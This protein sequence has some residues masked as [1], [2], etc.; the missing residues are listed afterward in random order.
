[1][2]HNDVT[3]EID[4]RRSTVDFKIYKFETL[5]DN[6]WTELKHISSDVKIKIPE[7]FVV[8]DKG[9]YIIE[10]NHSRDDVYLCAP[11]VGENLYNLFAENELSV[12]FDIDQ[13]TFLDEHMEFHRRVQVG[14]C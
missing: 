12:A 6:R 7:E 9:V 5:V 14:A 10:D 13:E 11:R 3:I 1:M 8:M 4:K 2:V